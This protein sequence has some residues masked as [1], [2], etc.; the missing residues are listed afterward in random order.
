M[1]PL[2]TWTTVIPQIH[3][4]GNVDHAPTAVFAKAKQIGTTYALNLGI[5]VFMNALKHHLL[6]CWAKIEQTILN[7]HVHLL[8]VYTHRLASVPRMTNS[9][10]ITTNQ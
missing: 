10:I 2:N 5:F 4:L 3:R 7:Q 6:V 9:N 1:T 8:V